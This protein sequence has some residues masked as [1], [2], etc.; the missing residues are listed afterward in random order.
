MSKLIYQQHKGK[1]IK[2]S[3]FNMGVEVNGDINLWFSSL[4]FK[5]KDIDECRKDGVN[6]CNHSYES[7]QSVKAFKRFIHKH[8]DEL[9]IG[10]SFT[11]ISKWSK[12][13]VSWTK[14]K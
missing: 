8:K 4:D 7:P 13:N 5:L 3:G 14:Y 12:Y 2:T 9:P 10:C 6:F 11:L 1:R